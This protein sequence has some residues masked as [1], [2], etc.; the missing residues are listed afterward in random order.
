MDGIALVLYF[1]H[2]FYQTENYMK[3]QIRKRLTILGTLQKN[4]SPDIMVSNKYIF[5]DEIIHFIHQR[6]MQRDVSSSD[7]RHSINV[8]GQFSGFYNKAKPHIIT[9]TIRLFSLQ[10]IF[11]KY[12]I[13]CHYPLPQCCLLRQPSLSH[14]SK[15]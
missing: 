7:K 10:R 13:K 6:K 15:Q 12:V 5:L 9:T 14:N 4:I 1:H 11:S 3:I 8:Y 2:T